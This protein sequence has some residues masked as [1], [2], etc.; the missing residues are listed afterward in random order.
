MKNDGIQSVISSDGPASEFK[1][2]FMVKLLHHLSLKFQ[3]TFM[4]K[5]SATSHGKGI[6][7]GIGGNVKRLVK[8]KMLSQGGNIVQ[9]AE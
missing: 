2:K 9:C 7:D 4:W 5:Y 1:N 6:V 3:R 8:Q